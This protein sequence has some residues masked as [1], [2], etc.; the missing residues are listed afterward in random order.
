MTPAPQLTLD[1]NVAIEVRDGTVLRGDVYR[2]SQPGQYPVILTHG[3]YGKDIHFKDFN[4]HAFALVQERG[5]FMNWE[6]VNPEWWVP[7][8][9]VVVRVDERGTGRSPGRMALFSPQEHQDFFDVIEWAGIQSW[10]NGKVGLLGISYYAIGQWHVAAL[11]PPHLAA[12]VAWE[13]AVD[14]YRDWAYHGGI[15]SN[16][17]TDAWWP[18]QITANQS[19]LD[20]APN[21]GV[22]VSGNA[23]LPGDLREHPLL[24]EYFEAR[25]AD[26]AQIDVPLLSAG[27]WAGYALHLRGNIEGY[28]AAGTDRKWLE[29]HSG[30]HFAPF[31]SDESRAYQKRFLDRWLCDNVE[32]WAEP[33]VKL[34][35]RRPGGGEFR[36]ENE[37]PIARTEWTKLNLDATQ[38]SLS[39]ESVER[40]GKVTYEAPAGGTVFYS[41]PFAAD[42]EIT[43][44][45][46]LNV[47]VEAGVS[48]I[49][50]FVT[51]LNIGPDGKEV[52]FEDASGNQG[53]VVKG[54][55]RLSHRALDADASAPW[56]PVHPHTSA[57]PL[58][59][60]EKVLACVEILPTSM[61]FERGHRLGLAIESHDRAEPSRFLH[62]DPI[63][64]APSV[65]AG[66][67]TI[68]TGRDHESFLLVPVIP[69]ATRE[70]A[71][72]DA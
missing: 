61:V 40:S 44:P 17:F 51:V 4:E 63:D 29:V 39:V 71:A 64:R 22:A 15:L 35:I 3:P 19:A 32:A 60:G 46:A 54:W 66:A 14:I 50:L 57:V 68:H 9:Y 11:R 23:D 53:P 42:T 12:I 24:D 70:E 6:T 33:P 59:P 20:G 43:G 28:L 31:Y 62:D 34:F 10:S 38:G 45:L 49:D 8:G 41:S 69:S 65:F 56:R 7:Q 72:P 52:L 26:L 47:W 48:D 5:P 36:Y 55:L 1:K 16:V 30:N 21:P 37:W 18:R 25:T 58:Q 27:N 2:P 13:G 67:N